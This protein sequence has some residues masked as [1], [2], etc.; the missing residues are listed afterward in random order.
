MKDRSRSEY[1]ATLVKNYRGCLSSNRK[2]IRLPFRIRRFQWLIAGLGTFERLLNTTTLI[3]SLR[4][5]QS[6]YSLLLPLAGLGKSWRYIIVAER[7]NV[8]E[9]PRPFAQAGNWPDLYRSVL[10]H[11]WKNVQA[12]SNAMEWKMLV[13]DASTVKATANYRIWLED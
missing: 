4:N 7:S 13:A 5:S 9:Q 2:S 1:T 6:R 3:W 10:R 11:Q 12:V 8:L